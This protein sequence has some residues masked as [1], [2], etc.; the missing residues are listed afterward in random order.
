MIFA[1]MKKALAFTAV[2]LIILAPAGCRD[3]R[4]P[5][6]IEC[7]RLGPIGDLH[8]LYEDAGRP[9]LVLGDS[10]WSCPC[11]TPR[12]LAGDVE[13]RH[14]AGAKEPRRIAGATEARSNAGDDERRRLAGD[15]ETRKRAGDD[16]S[17]R[18]AGNT[19]TRRDDGDAEKR[20][21]GGD[22]ETRTDDGDAETRRLAGDVE[23]R[24]LTGNAEDR[25]LGGQ[26]VTPTCAVVSTCPGFVVHHTSPRVS[27]FDGWSTKTMDKQ[28]VVP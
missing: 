27:V 8:A 24:D 1:A 9:L 20:R 17:R 11:G 16:E 21:L 10:V 15:T 25:R 7:E 4:S 13:S 5:A 28:C 2:A 18:L 14:V 22:T 23:R 6:Q 3:A 26:T 19:E 12:Q